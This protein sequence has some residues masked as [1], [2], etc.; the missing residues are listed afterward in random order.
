MT[1]AILLNSCGLYSK[2]KPVT[3]VPQHL[4]GM[5]DS[6]VAADS[7]GL[8]DLSWREMFT[9]PQ[10]QALIAS[11]LQQNTDLQV[12]HLKVKEDRKSVV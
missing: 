4:F 1:I 11:G 7:I 6:I 12:A 10:L 2:Y 9:D 3:E 8:G 5:A